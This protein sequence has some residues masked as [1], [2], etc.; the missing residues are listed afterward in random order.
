M[1]TAGIRSRKN[2]SVRY[3]GHMLVIRKKKYHCAWY[4]GF[5]LIFCPHMVQYFLHVIGF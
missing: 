4:V 1:M 2:H 3:T 5:S